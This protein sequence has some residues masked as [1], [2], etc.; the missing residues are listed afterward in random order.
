MNYRV[1]VHGREILKHVNQLRTL[2][3]NHLPLSEAA[4]ESDVT[5]VTPSPIA[6]E[7]TPEPQMV[8][9]EHP[10]VAVIPAKDTESHENQMD[11]EETTNQRRYPLRNRHPPD[12]LRF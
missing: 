12:R 2:Q 3:E 4:G 1:L 10:E 8:P 5:Q 9:S 11:L 7:R 6:T